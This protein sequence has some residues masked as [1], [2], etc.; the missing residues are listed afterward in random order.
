MDKVNF[1]MAFHC[2]QPVDNLEEVFEE[3]YKKSY[4]PFL[5]VLARHPGIKVSLHYSGSLLEWIKRKKPWF[6]ERI[7]QLKEKG[8]VEILTGG[9]FEP[10]LPMIPREDAKGQIRMLTRSIGEYFNCSPRGAWL[11]ERVWSPEVAAIFK[12]LNIKYTILDDFHF[13]QARLKKDDVFGFYSIKGIRDFYVFAAIKKLRYTMPF[14]DVGVTIDFLKTLRENP[15]A[16]CVTF[17]DDGEKFGLWPYTHDWVYNKGWLERFFTALEEQ[18]WVRTLTFTEAIGEIAPLGELEIPDSSYAEMIEWCNG[19]FRNF[20][21]KYPESK[22]MRNRMLH[23]SREIGKSEISAGNRVREELYKSQSNCAYWHGIFGGIYTNHLR[24]GIYSHIIKAENILNGTKPDEEKIELLSFEDSTRNIIRARNKFITVFINPDHAGSIFEIDYIPLSYNLV[25]TM[26][27]RYEPYHE[28]LNGKKNNLAALKKKA[29]DA[30]SDETVDLYEILG[31]R[32]RNLKKFLNYDSYQKSSCLCH[33]MNPNTSLEDFTKSLHADTHKDSL[34][35][36]YKQRIEKK[37]ER[38]IVKLEKSGSLTWERSAQ[39]RLVKCIILEKEP[40]IC[41]NFDLEN[42]SPETI[43]FIFGIEFNWSI[44]DRK[45]MRARRKRRVKSL[46]LA[47]K[48]ST[49]KIKHTF[50]APMGLWSFPVYTLNESER[51][52]GRSYQEVSLLFFRKLT[53]KSGARFSLDST[54]RISG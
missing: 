46:S 5:N 41:I 10:V 12:E 14:N 2:H 17:A 25:N 11:A 9:F 27:R 39:L 20:F 29:N 35:G 51:G 22:L 42:I 36:P 15:N 37:G 28:K 8:Q 6:I 3:A 4:E 13:K 21:E 26:S 52:M 54:L 34:L 7:K 32:E 38:L 47:D 40:E 30:A 48:F 1:L 24:R 45:F 19:N 23:V 43:R 53:L 18:S 49:I 44:E 33:A 50:G 16:R 31:V